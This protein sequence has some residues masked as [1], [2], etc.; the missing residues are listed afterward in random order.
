[1]KIVFLGYE[2]NR[3]YKFL[4]KKYQVLQ[5]LEIITLEEL[6]DF[7]PDLIIS[8]GYRHIIKKPIIDAFPEKIINLHISYLPYNR[9]ASPNL[10][11]FVED[12]IKGVTIHLVDE[13]IDTGDIMFQKEVQLG[14]SMTL[15]ESHEKLKSEIESLFMENWSLIRNNNSPRIKQS[16]TR[17]TYHTRKETQRCMKKLDIKNW[18]IK[19]KDLLMRSDEQIINDIQK[20]R[21]KNN[22]HWM[23]IVKLAFEVAPVE[24]R[25]IFKK[26]KYC[27]ER[28]NE[29]LKELAD[30]D[31]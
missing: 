12:S 1:M 24:S 10:W 7:N 9:G 20:I 13:G 8:Y 5:T 22:T 14:D 19:A 4:S 11:S 15:E 18:K 23:D 30:N 31:K 6:Q 21:E 29:L 26:I 3:L 25:S 28:V 17:G 16:L 2:N 27:D